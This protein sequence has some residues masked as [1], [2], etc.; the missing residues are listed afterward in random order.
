MRNA[1][2][3]R[4]LLFVFSM[5]IPYSTEYR[6]RLP[7]LPG[8]Y[9]FHM[10][11]RIIA[12]TGL[13]LWL[14]VGGFD[15]RAQQD[16]ETDTVSAS[17]VPE[18]VIERV[19]AAFENGDAD[20]LLDEAADRVEVS[21]PGT[22][23]YYSRSQAVYVLREFFDDHSPRRFEAKDVSTAGTSFFI[24]GRFWHVRSEQPLS[25]YTRFAGT[26]QVRLQEVR[27]EPVRR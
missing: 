18:A 13:A 24:T 3:R 23:A 17:G 9:R 2:N 5:A 12:L 16:P 4:G 11:A 6:I 25:V 22:R 1:K 7:S 15:A 27:I 19:E 8:W 14:A 20:L 21:L 10:V 26:D